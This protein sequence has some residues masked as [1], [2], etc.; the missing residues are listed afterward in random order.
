MKSPLPNIPSTWPLV[1]LGD[2]ALKIGS[3]A[4]PLGGE[5]VYLARR[6]RFAL[7]RSQAV[8]DHFFDLSSL[9][10]ITDEDARRLG[11]AEVNPGDVLLNITGDGVTFARATIAPDEALPACV[12]QHVCII[13]P[14]REKLVPGFLLA[15]LTHP[16]IKGYIESFNAGGSRRAITKGHIESFVIPLAPRAVQLAIASLLEAIN[17]KIELNR[18]TNET[19]EAVTRAIFKDWFFDFGPTRARRE[20][21]SPYIAP[22]IWALFPSSFSDDGIP[23]G[24]RRGELQEIVTLNPKESLSSG[25]LAPYL[26]MAALPTSGSCPE[27]PIER[28]FVS[29]MRFRNGDT[30]VARITPCLENGKTAFVQNL[31]DQAIGWGSTEFIVM[32]PVPPVAKPYA[33]LLARDSAFRTRAIQSMTGT[34]GRQ[35]A[36][37][38]LLAEYPVTIPDE[39]IWNAFSSIVEPIFERIK[40]ADAESQILVNMRGLMLPKLVSGEIQLKH[41]ERMIEE[42]L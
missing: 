10:Y 16:A 8:H 34:S 39:S 24:W 38:E 12:N 26:D 1:H 28:E 30:L 7:I 21:S 3:G 31:P 29:G 25:T 6:D 19:L 2:L 5:Q 42:V 32:R 17:S 13:R 14:D 9:S 23:A 40:T 36:R 22:D 4:T 11:N 33:Y 15:Y 18:K 20:N 35:R 37:T 41:A 27:P